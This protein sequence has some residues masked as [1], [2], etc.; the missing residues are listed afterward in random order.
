[1]RKLLSIFLILSLSSSITISVI[2]RTISIVPFTT[3]LSCANAYADTGQSKSS[4]YRL[5]KNQ[6][7]AAFLALVACHHFY[8]KN[9]LVGAFYIG[10]IALVG[11]GYFLCIIDF[12]VILNMNDIEWQRY[13]QSDCGIPWLC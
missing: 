6:T 11:L 9:N 7:L 10:L 1:M 8:L 5:D 2:N 12:F 4:S 3:L 13:L